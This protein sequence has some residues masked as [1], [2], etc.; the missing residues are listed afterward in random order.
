MTEMNRPTPKFWAATLSTLVFAAALFVIWYLAH[1]WMPSY[2]GLLREPLNRFYATIAAA[3]GPNVADFV[4][5]FL[6]TTPAFL[7]G[8]LAYCV[9]R[10]RTLSDKEHLHCLKCGYILKGLSEPRCPECGERI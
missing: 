6:L 8:L 2:A 4:D 1:G 5:G 10:R 7:I 3:F 9:L